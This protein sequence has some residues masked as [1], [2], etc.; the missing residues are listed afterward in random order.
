VV[1]ALAALVNVPLLVILGRLFAL[2]L[3]RMA[4]H[5][6]HIRW[7]ALGAVALIVLIALVRSW[8]KR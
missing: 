6:A 3:D 8:Q 2:Q 5:V 1:D 7:Y 4:A